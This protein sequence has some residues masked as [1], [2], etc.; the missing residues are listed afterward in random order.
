[1]QRN[2]SLIYITILVGLILQII[3]MPRQIDFYR[4]DWLLMI[5]CYWSMA[6]PNRVSVGIAA[7][8]GFILDVLFGTALGVHS[9]ALAIPVFIVGANYQR[10]RNQSMMQQAFVMFVLST[11]YHLT[12]YWLQYLLVNTEFRWAF[13][14]PTIT[15]I[16]LWP[17]L[18]WFLR[19]I[20]RRFRVS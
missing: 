16:I 9:F 3:P 10:I 2:S 17:W 4:P 11:V 5:L 7:I 8:C 15:T 20:R 14:Y 13:F 19:R 6:L 1:M 12:I 18:F